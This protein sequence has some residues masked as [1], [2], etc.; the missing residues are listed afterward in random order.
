MRRW[1]LGGVAWVDGWVLLCCDR[2][3]LRWYERWVGIVSCKPPFDHGGLSRVVGRL[4]HMIFGVGDLGV[5]LP[6]GVWWSY[7]EGVD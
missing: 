2:E 1:R 3:V 5:A 6:A 4:A 7:A